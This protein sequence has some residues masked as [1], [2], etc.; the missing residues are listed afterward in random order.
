MLRIDELGLMVLMPV[1]PLH[2]QPCQFLELRVSKAGEMQRGDRTSGKAPKR[3]GAAVQNRYKCRGRDRS[4]RG[5]GVRREGVCARRKIW[6]PDGRAP[7]VRT[8]QRR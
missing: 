2:M 8:Q 3:D 6:A 4:C 1:P 7:R 5:M